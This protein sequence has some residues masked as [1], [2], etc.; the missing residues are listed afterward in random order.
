MKRSKSLLELSHEHHLALV[1]AKRA[2][3][4]GVT[5]TDQTDSLM[6]QAIEKFAQDLELHFQME[7]DVLLPEMKRAGKGELVARTLIEHAHLRR[8]VSEL[9]ARDATAMHRFGDVLK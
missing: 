1:L 9:A 6:A 8:M 2:Q 4:M 7:E 5:G 3:R